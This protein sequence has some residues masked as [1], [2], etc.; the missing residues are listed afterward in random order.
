MAQGLSY[1]SLFFFFI[2]ECWSYERKC[3]Y[4]KNISIVCS[5]GRA[6]INTRIRKPAGIIMYSSWC[7]IIS[8]SSSNIEFFKCSGD[9]QYLSWLT[10]RLLQTAY[11]HLV[12]NS[13]PVISFKA[14]LFRFS[15]YWERRDVQHHVEQTLLMIVYRLWAMSE[16]LSCPIKTR[17]FKIFTLIFNNIVW[18]PWCVCARALALHTA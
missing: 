9:Q 2:F 11:V 8:V 18:F 7:Y 14:F 6:N 1:V 10:N 15:W 16:V 4:E 12:S 13:A 5:A 17:R 3:L